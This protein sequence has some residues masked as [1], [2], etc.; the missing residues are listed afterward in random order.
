MKKPA[1]LACSRL[2]GD[3]TRKTSRIPQF[4]VMSDI[5]RL[6]NPS[7]VFGHLPKGSAVVL[8]HTDPAQLEHLARTI[9]PKARKQGFKVLIS[10]HVHLALRLGADG[11]HLSQAALRLGLWRRQRA[12]FRPG[13]LITAAHH[14]FRQF[15][16]T[17]IDA[18]LLSPV[19][20]T[21][22]HPKTKPM[23]IMRC[24]HMV[25]QSPKPV[26]GLGGIT[27]KNV[28]RL[29][30]SGLFGIAAIGAWL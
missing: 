1:A 27:A 24:V 30:G 14:G 12:G 23:G 29:K 19:F 15:P 13:F 7:V 22:S 4:F 8:R 3:K 17:D 25:K 6:P 18:Y 20:F 21:K 9:L 16:K 2:W 10:N 11:V 5:L 26:I 28:G